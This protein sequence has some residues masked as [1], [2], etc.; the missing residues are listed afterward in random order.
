M[1]FHRQQLIATNRRDVRDDR[2][3]DDPVSGIERSGNR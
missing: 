2:I 3:N 1:L